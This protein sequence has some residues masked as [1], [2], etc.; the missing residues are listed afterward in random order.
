[1]TALSPS[2]DAIADMLRSVRTIAVVGISA[3]ESRPSFTVARYLQA[4]GYRIVPV[5]PGLA[6]QTLL[7]ET[8]HPDLES[9]PEPV[10]MVDIFRNSEAAGAVT[11]AAIRI[12][13]KAVWMQLDVV[14]QAAA[15][16][17]R[18]AG[19]AVVMDRCPKIEI[20][21]LGL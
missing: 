14:N 8:V 18:A 6:G 21:R 19:L 9:I 7:G 15:E 11:D 5:N 10:D 13:A 16:R 17:A 12:G 3:N 1:M 20:A 4:K 2:D